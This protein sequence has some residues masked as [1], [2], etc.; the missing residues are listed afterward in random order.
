MPTAESAY[1]SDLRILDVEDWRCRCDPS[2]EA[3]LLGSATL[4]L[5]R[6]VFVKA[7]MDCSVVHFRHVNAV[8]ADALAQWSGL[9]TWQASVTWAVM[10][11][12]ARSALRTS[13]VWNTAGNSPYART[14]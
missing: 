3:P 11:L 1:R 4:V 5:P 8:M 12:T 7:F 10:T 14:V 6:P 9:K 2:T 13:S